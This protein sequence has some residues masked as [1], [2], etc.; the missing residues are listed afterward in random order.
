MSSYVALTRVE[1]RSDLLRFRPFPRHLFSQEQKQGPDLLLQVWRQDVAVDWKALEEQYM[2]RR[3]RPGCGIYKYKHDCCTSEWGKRDKCGNRLHCIDRRTADGLPFECNNCLQW[4][5]KEAFLQ[6]Q[7]RAVSTHT[8]VCDQCLE[9]REC[10]L[11]KEHNSEQL[12]L[13]DNGRK[14]RQREETTTEQR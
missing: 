2:P 10:I 6:H 1:R 5:A 7:L 8:R 4:K 14:P 11:C 3:N 9:R 13:Q 12:L